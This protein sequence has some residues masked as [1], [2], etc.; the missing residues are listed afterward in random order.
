ML[1]MLEYVNKNSDYVLVNEQAL[2]DFVR[3]EDNWEYHYWLTDLKDDLNERQ[4]IIFA[5]VCES[6]NFC[7]WKNEK[8]SK[9]YVGSETIFSRMKETVLKNPQ[10]LDV[11]WLIKI[12][13]TQ[14]ND[15]FGK[16]QDEIPLMKKRYDLFQNWNRSFFVLIS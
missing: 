2:R 14:F 16:S 15:F 5:F 9:N 3:K 8:Y 11:E 7:F 13:E 10:I 12:D 1:D 4:R 6:I